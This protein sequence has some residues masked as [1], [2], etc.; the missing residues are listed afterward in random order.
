MKPKTAQKIAFS[1]LFL[2]NILVIIPVILIIGVILKNG[3][4]AIN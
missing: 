2:A 4:S 3:I 1:I